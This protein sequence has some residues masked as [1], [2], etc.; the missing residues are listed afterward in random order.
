MLVTNYDTINIFGA[1]DI[2]SSYVS[3]KIFQIKLKNGELKE[4]EECSAGLLS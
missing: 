3:C 2:H 4:L 1:V